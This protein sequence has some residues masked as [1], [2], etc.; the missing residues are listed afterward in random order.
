VAHG[1]HHG[2]ERFASGIESLIQ[3]LERRYTPLGKFRPGPFEGWS[4]LRQPAWLGFVGM[5]LI[6][7]GGCFPESPFKVNIAGTWFFGE[8]A[9]APYQAPS[10]TQLLLAIVLTYG[11]L[12]LLMR[13]WLRLAQI[14][15]NH[16]GAPLRTLWRIFVLWSVPMIVAPPLFSRD[17]FSYAA[18][19]EMTAHGLS[20]YLYGPF[21][22]GAGPY[23]TPVDPLW[24]NAP[25]PYGPFFLYID[26]L[27]DRLAQHNALATV[28]GLRLVAFAAM[29]LIGYAVVLLAKA[30]RRDASEAFALAVLNP[31]LII[32]LVNGSHNDV[33]MTAFLVL[34]IALALRRRLWWAVVFCACAASIKAPAIIGLAF[35]AWNWAG[36]GAPVRERVRPI[37]ITAG[38]SAAVLGVWTYLAGFGFGWVGDLFSNGA[39]RS[40]AA[41]ATGIGMAL[42]LGLR[43]M[44][45]ETNLTHDL[46]ISRGIGLGIALVF[47]AVM[48]V[49]G[50]RRGWVRSLALA[51]LL[52]VLL[53]PVVQP[54]YLS[55]SL[56]LLAATYEGREYFW[57]LFLTMIGPVIG[58]PG[59]RTLL[60]GLSQANPLLIA[61][62]VAV[63]GG[64]LLLPMGRWTQWSWPEEKVGLEV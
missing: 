22:L 40:W 16:V 18:Q 9:N 13:V 43:H 26:G 58:L 38:M 36:P 59:G 2:Y 4:F 23:V 10:Q 14:V 35:I 11:G 1:V 44:G 41:P 53:G 31:M 27:V 29:C 8:P 62:A 17:V 20:P 33:I 25:A 63:L 5:C 54:W 47:A 39:V 12:V 3:S 21:T 37:A 52:V 30:M 61:V 6:V 60:A 46:T 49:T 15:H 50:E 64:V 51:L 55:W 32:E 42:Q 7:A 19:G 45:L 56:V 57:L 34:S 48:F 24:G 28:V